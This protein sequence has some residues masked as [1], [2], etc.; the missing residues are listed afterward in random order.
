MVNTRYGRN[1][2]GIAT[3]EGILS[4]RHVKARWIKAPFF[5]SLA[6]ARQPHGRKDVHVGHS[7]VDV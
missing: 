5:G 1:E 3:N 6:E 2:S 4:F 7:V